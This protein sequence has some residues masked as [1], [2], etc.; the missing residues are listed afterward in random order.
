MNVASKLPLFLAELKRRK[1]TRVA[2]VYAVVGIGVIEGAQLLF[3]ALALPLV[4]WRVLAILIFLGFPVALVLAWA[5]EVTPEGIQRTPD[6]TPEQLSAQTPGKSTSISWVLAGV[7]LAVALAAGYFTFFRDR[8]PTPQEDLVAVFPL[9]NR[10]G[11]SALDPLGKTAAYRIAAGFGTV[12]PWRVLANND[13]ESVLKGAGEAASARN[14]GLELGA[15][16]AITGHITEIGDTL[17]FW[18]ELMD[19]ST[20]E[21]F[22]SFE[23]SGSGTFPTSVLEDLQQRATSAAVLMT[24]VDLRALPSVPTYEAAQSYVR[25]ISIFRTGDWAG[26]LPH[27]LESYEADTTFL[28]PLLSA[29]TAFVNLELWYEADSTVAILGDRR[30]EMSRS[31]GL[32]FE[33]AVSNLSGNWPEALRLRRLMAQEDPAR[34]GGYGLAHAALMAGYPAEALEALEGVLDEGQESEWLWFWEHLAWANHALGRHREALDAA[35]EG[36][37]LFPDFLLLRWR[38][39]QAL[40][41]MERLEQ[42]RPLLSE[43]EGKDPGEYSSPG[44]VLG[45]VAADLARFGHPEESRQAAERAIERYRTRD[46]DRFQMDGADLL[47]RAGRPLEAV[48]LLLPLV[49]AAPDDINLR[50][51]LGVALAMTDDQAQAEVQ[52]SWLEELDRPYLFG[53]DTYWRAAILAHLDGRDEA[54]RLLRQALGEGVPYAVLVSPSHFMPLWG[55]EPF[56]QL[57]APKG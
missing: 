55:Y 50:G 28:H 5:V 4:A 16:L 24:V 39:I 45:L 19:V 42:I 1:V 26:S 33:S 21:R 13:V 37:A 29:A 54:T 9:E 15:D 14:T 31:Q 56:E 7:G 30:A 22:A 44:W 46:P 53:L 43:L 11:D 32:Q 23:V 6:L 49:E 35:R 3:E 51:L 8:E 18:W 38:E 40:V 52:A 27:F 17:L 57:V 48:N 47:L 20:G 25:G 10:T 41:A 36:Q 2:V 12:G 34:W